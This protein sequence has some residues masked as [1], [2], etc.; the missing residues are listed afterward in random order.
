MC[1]SRGAKRR[2]LL[3]VTHESDP[4][5]RERYDR[6]RL[7]ILRSLGIHDGPLMSKRDPEDGQEAESEHCSVE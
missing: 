6:R 2:W 4:K 3:V 5:C 1:S 7:E